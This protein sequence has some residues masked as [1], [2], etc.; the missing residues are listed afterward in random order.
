[1]KETV[2]VTTATGNIGKPAVEYLLKKGFKV[3][4]ASRTP[5]SEASKK[6][7]A[8]GAMSVLMDFE[9]PETIDSALEG[10]DKILFNLT[11]SDTFLE[12]GKV[13][14]EKIK[15]SKIKFICK[16]SSMEAGLTEDAIGTWHEKQENDMKAIGLPY[17]VLRPNAYMQNLLRIFKMPIRHLGILS[18][19]FGHGKMSYV[20][21]RDIAEVSSEVL[22]RSN[23]PLFKNQ[24]IFLHGPE[25]VDHERVAEIITQVVGRNV[26]HVMVDGPE[27]KARVLRFVDVPESTIDKFI[28]MCEK[29]VKRDIAA[30]T[31]TAIR[32]ILKRPAR[33]VEEYI[34]ENKMEFTPPMIT[35]PTLVKSLAV[36][37]VLA[38]A[39]GA[40]YFYSKK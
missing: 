18:S 27:F 35:T 38:V 37:A 22:A 40:Y 34:R 3:K 14:C 10:V 23:D 24:T 26:K 16:I 4:A 1:M 12:D 9:R 29:V 20:D 39:G 6:L 17:T 33:T 2:L 8:A 32:D 36:V 7:A 31:N 11:F 21:C 13:L 5:D 19:P 25:I 15:K 28:E 30:R